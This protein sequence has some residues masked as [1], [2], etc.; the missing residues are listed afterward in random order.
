[1]N[2]GI[3]VT[4]SKDLTQ[5]EKKINECRRKCVNAGITFTRQTKDNLMMFPI[6][7]RGLVPEHDLIVP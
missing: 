4:P 3:V 2:S 7:V 1:M 6:N 5:V